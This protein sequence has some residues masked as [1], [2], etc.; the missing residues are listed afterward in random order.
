[1]PSGT[2]SE[3][4]RR[5]QKDELGNI[6]CSGHT[7][8]SLFEPVDGS[9]NPVFF[10][11]NANGAFQNGFQFGATTSTGIGFVG[12]NYSLI[13]PNNFIVKDGTILVGLTNDP[14]TTS[15]FDSHLWGFTAP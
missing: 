5:M 9:M 15:V 10:R 12:L 13:L 6:Y 11:V 7:R 3:E 14:V 1:M 8:S 2:D 4:P